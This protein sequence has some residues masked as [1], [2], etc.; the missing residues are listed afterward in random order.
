MRLSGVNIPYIRYN[1]DGSVLFIIHF[2]NPE[3]VDEFAAF[4]NN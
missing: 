3:L 2:M 1:H 4:W